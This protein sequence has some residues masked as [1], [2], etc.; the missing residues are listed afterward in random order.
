MKK[1]SIRHDKRDPQSAMLGDGKIALGMIFGVVFTVLISLIAEVRQSPSNSFLNIELTPVIVSLLVALAS[2]FLATNALLEQRKSREAATDPVLIVHLGQREDARELV[3]FNISNVG[4]GAA[5]NVAMTVEKPKDGTDGR[6]FVTNIF[7]QYHP[8]AVI[9]QGN[10]IEF[11]FAV[12]WEILGEKLLPS[13]QVALS[14]EDLVG[15]QYESEFTIDVREMKG[16]GANKSPQMRMV[17]ALE[18]IA[19]K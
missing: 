15:G 4:A 18:A 11:S 10:S 8:F 19:K 2:T 6:N 12:G 3:T 14:Y 1:Y 5:L 13:F 9:L 7:R 16:L 17:T